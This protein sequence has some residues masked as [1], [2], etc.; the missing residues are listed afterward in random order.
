[1]ERETKTEFVTGRAGT[2]KTYVIKKRIEEDPFYGVLCATTGIAAVNMSGSTG[3]SVTTINSLLRYFNTESL[4]E[5]FVQRRLHRQLKRIRK[6]NLVL[7]EVSM[8]E[9]AQL[10]PIVDALD[11][12]NDHKDMERRGGLGLVLTGDFAQLPPVSIGNGGQ[13][14]FESAHWERFAANTTRL[15]KIHRQDEPAFIDALGFAR[16]GDGDRLVDLL[17][18]IAPFSSKL[19][20]DFPGTTIF[21]K[22]KYVDNMNHVRLDKLIRQGNKP[23]SVK[24][25]RWGRQRSE[26]K[27]IPEELQ[28]CDN[29][30]VMIL[31]N[32]SPRF[33]FANG[34][35]GAIVH[36]DSTG[37]KV[38]VRL[39]RNNKIVTVSKVERLLSTRSEVPEDWTIPCTALTFAQYRDWQN[40]EDE[41]KQ[42]N[43]GKT[44]EEM[45]SFY[46]IYLDALT[47]NLRGPYGTAY[48]D[49]RTKK[50]IVGGIVYLPIRCAWACTVHKTQ[51]LTLNNV[52]IDYS[53]AF[54]RS[55][56][57]SYVAL[58]R[59]RSV[60]GLRIV[61]TPRLVASRTNVFKKVLQW[62]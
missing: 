51:G 25:F 10:N 28:L 44:R 56:S 22:N 41:K 3:N 38:A 11:E 48:Y 45:E 46:E 50:W 13:F 27:Q 8:M 30:Y 34:D 18:S 39:A 53:D 32:D 19:D 37:N 54:M 6:K 33:T 15:E 2:G 20:V 14:A 61:G 57:M 31:S 12:I 29:A 49:F 36:Y 62:Q 35:C 40:E 43:V 59:A 1:M 60:K 4:E 16:V 24:S 52:Q 55:P 47:A 7:D 23:F 42:Y 26:W 5:A 58:S 17:D 21:P 9:A